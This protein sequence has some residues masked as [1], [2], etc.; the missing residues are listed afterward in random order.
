MIE[1]FDKMVA[2]IIGALLIGV[3]LNGFLVPHRLLDGGITGIALI[4]HYYFGYPTGFTMFLLST[5]LFLYTWFFERSYFFNSFIGMAITAVFIDGMAP[6]RTVFSFS[7]YTSVILAG[8]FIGI[9][10]GIM[11]RYKTSTGGTD[12]LAQFLSNTFSMNVGLVIFLIDGL[13]VAAAFNMLE[14]KAVLFSCFTISIIGIFTSFIA[15][16]H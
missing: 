15:R 1:I 2:I 11:L 12:L 13:I 4:L 6:L 14:L 7:I 10:V 5:P 9:G 16:S 8:V 3:G